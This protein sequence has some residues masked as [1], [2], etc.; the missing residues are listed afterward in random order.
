MTGAWRERDRGNLVHARIEVSLL[1]ILRCGRQ[2][3]TSRWIHT[4]HGE[5][6]PSIQSGTS[7]GDAERDLNAAMVYGLLCRSPRSRNASRVLGEVAEWR[8]TVRCID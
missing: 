1:L 8:S 7:R 3:G 4:R 5:L 6:L 2:A